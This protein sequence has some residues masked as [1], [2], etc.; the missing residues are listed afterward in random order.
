MRQSKHVQTIIAVKGVGLVDVVTVTGLAN[1]IN[2]SRNSVLRYEK[3]GVFPMAPIM[4]GS[5]RYYPISLARK[6][7]PIVSKFPGH[8]RPDDELIVEIDRLF[9]EEKDKLCQQK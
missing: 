2:K 5:K 8:K 3:L 9:K 4:L 1:I 7:A 6:L